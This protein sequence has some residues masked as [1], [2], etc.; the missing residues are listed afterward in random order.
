MSRGQCVIRCPRGSRLGGLAR[1]VQRE[2]CARLGVG[3]RGPL[4]LGSPAAF[5]Q[6][7]GRWWSLHAVPLHDLV[8][9]IA[10]DFGHVFTA[11]LI[12]QRLCAKAPDLRHVC[13]AILR[14]NG[15]PTC[16]YFLPTAPVFVR[17]HSLLHSRGGAV[18][19]AAPVNRRWCLCSLRCCEDG[20]GAAAFLSVNTDRFQRGGKSVATGP[21][22][23][24]PSIDLVLYLGLQVV[25]QGLGVA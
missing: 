24:A 12:E 5:V 13:A 9:A 16:R 22:K 23:R 4:L 7:D 21:V 2:H 8:L 6:R 11:M 25:E 10:T 17:H 3:L 15:L 14:N 20:D 19:Q 1:V 18:V